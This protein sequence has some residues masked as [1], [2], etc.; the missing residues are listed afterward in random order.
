MEETIT[1][2][3]IDFARVEEHQLPIHKR[4]LNWR[5]CYIVRSGASAVVALDRYCRFQAHI[6]AG[7]TEQQAIELVK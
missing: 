5:D 6:R 4:L 2:P 1:K 7:F 3:T